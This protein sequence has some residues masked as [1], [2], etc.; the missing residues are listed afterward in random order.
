MKTLTI[1]SRNM[2]K[3]ET[4]TKL[5]GGALISWYYGDTIKN[6]TL[7]DICL[8]LESLYLHNGIQASQY[9]NKFLTAHSEL[10]A[11]PGE[12]F[13]KNHT[14][15]LFFRNIHNSKYKPKVTYLQ[16]TNATLDECVT[17]IRKT[18]RDII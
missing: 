1:W 9:I 14:V 17:T 5:G 11:I 7:E 13:S 6:E 16:N 8:R 12:S 15:F 4:D 2:Q 18:E 3:Q 10:E